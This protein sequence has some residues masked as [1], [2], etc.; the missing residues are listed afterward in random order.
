MGLWLVYFAGL[1][2]GN[3]VLAI[4]FLCVKMLSLMNLAC[5]KSVFVVEKFGYVV[6]NW[7]VN[8]FCDVCLVLCV[9]V[10]QVVG[11]MNC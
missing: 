9:C 1:C 11:V 10:L 6:L 8:C 5:E 3:S 4:E 7:C 2:V